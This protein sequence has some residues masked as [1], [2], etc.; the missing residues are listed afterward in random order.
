M[1][2]QKMNPEE[3]KNIILERIDQNIDFRT[4]RKELKG[5][6]RHDIKLLVL[7]IIDERKISEVPFSGMMKKPVKATPP[8]MIEDGKIPVQELLEQKGFLAESCFVKYS[9]GKKKITM[10]IKE[11]KTDVHAE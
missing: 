8:I 1:S 10:T 2:K 4:L 6:S 9:V 11:K 7:E 3:A 5:I